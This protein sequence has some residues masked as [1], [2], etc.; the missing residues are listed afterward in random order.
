MTTCCA[1]LST[2]SDEATSKSATNRERFIIYF[3]VNS[4]FSAQIVIFLR[5]KQVI[6][7][8]GEEAIEAKGEKTKKKRSK[9]GKASVEDTS[10]QDAAQP[11][12]DG[13]EAPIG[14]EAKGEKK[15]RA[16]RKKKEDAPQATEANVDNLAPEVP[17]SSEPVEQE[18]TEQL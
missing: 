11:L 15:K 4:K 1:E 12:Q 5:I 16:P 9:K 7:R 2:T 14:E 13:A 3:S 10:L 6:L 8:G 18:K 17:A